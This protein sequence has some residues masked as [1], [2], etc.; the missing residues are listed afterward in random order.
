MIKL[1]RFAVLGAAVVSTSGC[2]LLGIGA[3]GSTADPAA[4]AALA[5]ETRTEFNALNSGNTTLPTTG[6]A[7][8]SGFLS[9]VVKD[10]AM[11]NGS[12][13]QIG[14]MLVGDANFDVAFMTN[15]VDFSGTVNN[16]LAKDEVDQTELYS[17]LTTGTAAELEALLD[18]YDGTT[19]ELVFANGRLDTASGP[20]N[21]TSDVSGTV[22]HNGD[23]LAFGGTTRGYFIGANGEGMFINAETHEGLTITENGID[24]VGDFGVRLVQTN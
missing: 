5:V 16:I 9:G 6:D 15:D 10:T 1:I 19:G 14:R 17:V 12:P 11:T 8:Y 21:I 23:A 3:G 24:R 2:A 20:T 18:T 22:T 7:N 13:T 4:T